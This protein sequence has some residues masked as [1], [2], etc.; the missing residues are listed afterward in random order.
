[1][2]SK[3][4]EI[5]RTIE[6]QGH[7]IQIVS[8]G[9]DI[10]EVSALVKELVNERDLLLKRQDNLTLLTRLYD[11]TVIE[12]GELAKQIEKETREQT[13]K[14]ATTILTQAHERAKVMVEQQQN[15]A[16]LLIQQRL[17]AIKSNVKKQLE[18][19]HKQEIEKLQSRI[20]D[21]AQR[22]SDDIIAQEESL[23]KQNNLV[24]VDLDENMF[25]TVSTG[26]TPKTAEK[27]PAQNVVKTTDPASTV[28]KA[29]TPVTTAAK[30]NTSAQTAVKATAPTPA[31]ARVNPTV[32]TITGKTDQD[33][34]EFE[35][36]LPRD[37]EEIDNVNKLLAAIP[38]IKNTELLTQ[39][40][41]SLFKVTLNKPVDLLPRLQAL[42]GVYS[43]EASGNNGQKKILISFAVK[44]R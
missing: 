44:S 33:A 3:T 32:V 28:V 25:E 30:E 6:L 4:V 20:K 24:E 40:S 23:I 13:Q 29:S 41:K 10:E 16:K 35:I 21:A 1:M 43:A 2:E 5:N 17:K 34:T 12:A 18:T 42:P 7:S 26:E 38:E 15:E 22:V 9:L 31:A 8:N 39:N 14:E 11:K 37:Q 36:S 27:A 19:L